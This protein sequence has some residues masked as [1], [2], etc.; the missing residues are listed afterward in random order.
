MGVTAAKQTVQRPVEIRV[1]FEP[2]L[3]T[4]L[5]ASL[6]EGEVAPMTVARVLGRGR[7]LLQYHGFTLMAH[8]IPE[9]KPGET[10]PVAV[11]ELGPP[12]VLAP[13]GAGIETA[14]GR[15]VQVDSAVVPGTVRES[16]PEA[17]S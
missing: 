5:Y 14:P 13:W 17:R 16:G 15:V 11:K 7:A 6:H 12:L 9:W 2:G 4:A 10:F 8:G 3:G 1:R